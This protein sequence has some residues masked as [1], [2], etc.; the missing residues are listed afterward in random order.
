MIGSNSVGG[1][2]G[3]YRWNGSNWDSVDGGAV[4]IAVGFDGSVWVTGTN[5]VGGGFGIY[6]WN[7]TGWDNVSGGAVNISVSP[8][9][10]PWVVNSEGAIY[11]RA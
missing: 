7:G 10:L 9:G 3:I 4:R 2:Y 1:G 5:K 6:R 8:N 11:R